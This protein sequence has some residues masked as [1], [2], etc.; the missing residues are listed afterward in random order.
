MSGV[1]EAERLLVDDPRTCA[2]VET[3]AIEA[4][5]VAATQLWVWTSEAGPFSRR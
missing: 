3:A 2:Y 4:R 1:I 5:R